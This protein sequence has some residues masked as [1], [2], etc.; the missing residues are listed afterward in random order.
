VSNA[1]AGARRAFWRPE[2]SDRGASRLCRAARIY[3]ELRG[4]A[5]TWPELFPLRAQVFPLDAGAPGSRAAGATVGCGGRVSDAHVEASPPDSPAPHEVAA[6]EQFAC[7]DC[8]TDGS[9][10]GP[11][12]SRAAAN[13]AF[14]AGRPQRSWRR[15][16]RGRTARS[17]WLTGE[18]PGVFF[19][20]P[21]RIMNSGS[22]EIGRRCVAAGWTVRE[23]TRYRSVHGG[24]EL[25][26]ATLPSI[27]GL[28]Q[29]MHSLCTQP[30]GGLSP[31]AERPQ[32]ALRRTAGAVPSG[33][34]DRG[35]RLAVGTRTMVPRETAMRSVSEERVQ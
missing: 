22:W 32:D 14:R 6:R 11:Y 17:R 20:G 30:V 28:A 24:P 31:E 33:D 1:A 27:R 29:P 4:V 7:N 18:G 35:T 8:V 9:P 23:S 26:P 3:A 25:G 2:A 5:A 15:T 16:L 19:V 13:Q 10:G 21:K 12:L 34:T